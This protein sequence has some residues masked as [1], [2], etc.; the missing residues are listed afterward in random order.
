M[1]GTDEPPGDWT[2]EELEKNGNILLARLREH[3]AAIRN[4]PV[5]SDISAIELQ[6]RIDAPLP[7]APTPFE[8]V[9]DETWSDVVPHLAL[10][11][12]PNFHAYFSNSSSGPAILAETL[13]AALNVNCQ[14]WR[15]A[16]AASA[17]ERLV[18]RWL[19]E[20]AGYPEDADGVLVN[21]ASL[22]TV[23]ALI[24]ARDAHGGLR[25]RERG[26][27]GRDLPRM[28]VYTSDQ[29]H[30]SVDKAAIALG[31]G[32]DNVVRL[33]SGPD[34][35]L[36]PGELAKTLDQD[37]ADGVLP[38]AV[39]ATAGT[40]STGAIDPVSE[41]ARVC[42]ER[43]VW[44]HV[45]AAY[46]GFWRLVDR[47][48]PDL[49][50]LAAADSVVVNPHKVLFCPME[51]SALYCKRGGALANAFKLVPEYL[52]TSPD[53]G[54]VDYMDHSLQLGRQFRALKVWWVLRCFGR[55]GLS[56]L[57]TA[58]A[59]YADW[60]RS[61]ARASP[62]WTVPAESVLPL[63]CLR[64]DPGTAPPPGVD[65]R[66]WIDRLNENI[67]AAIH[68]SGRS[69]VSHTRLDT[70]YVIRVSIGNIQTTGADVRAL[71]ALLQDTAAECHPPGEPRR[72][73]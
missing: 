52:R 1:I 28:R 56:R 51:V 31:I 50:D 46:G 34:L 57:L 19:A 62:D 4:V 20:L 54:S 41:L 25:V 60:L 10:W 6:R 26:L 55:A 71:W 36:D 43:N 49:A 3:F 39:C 5:T 12:H 32:L 59:G 42:A 14:Q 35:R 9:L 67:C 21:G 66:E 13:T 17:V 44:L 64:Y 63:V 7:E 37:I 27:A 47:L 48:A 22:A 8:Q 65:R 18:L 45:D 69:F 15:T 16:P 72:I 30:S 58:R 24:A 29:A 11:H 23:Y 70:G 53:E 61:A 33:R 2:P 38:L 40:T 73:V 68:R